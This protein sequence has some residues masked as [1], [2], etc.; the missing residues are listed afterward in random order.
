ML[1]FLS[2]VYFNLKVLWVSHNNKPLEEAADHFQYWLS[3]VP[4]PIRPTVSGMF[5][6]LPAGDQAA[7]Y[8]LVDVP[9][10]ERRNGEKLC[11]DSVYVLVITTTALVS[12]CQLPF[13]EVWSFLQ[14]CLNLVIIDEAQQFP[15]ATDAWL[16]TISEKPP[17]FVLVGDQA[18]P[19]GASSVPFTQ[20]LLKVQL[21]LLGGLHTIQTC[22]PGR[23][24]HIWNTCTCWTQPQGI[25]LLSIVLHTWSKRSTQA[26][27]YHLL[28]VIRTSLDS[29]R[30][31][32]CC[33]L[34]A[35][36]S[37]MKSTNQ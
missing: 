19:A 8:D 23:R 30:Q 13:A 15:D 18:Q 3:T 2:A 27:A 28:C 16:L 17:L 34:S 10:D 35:Q 37:P 22:L 5:R 7:K 24:A 20:A 33:C 25:A 31:V 21:K 29:Q 36:E 32:L 1:V 6:R 4:T 9:F 12:T 26:F 14:H 11:W